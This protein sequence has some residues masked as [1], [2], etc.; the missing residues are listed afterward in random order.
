M[1]GFDHDLFD[2]KKKEVNTLTEKITF[3]QFPLRQEI[4]CALNKKKF[5]NPSPVQ[6]QV[7]NET[8]IMDEDLIVQAKT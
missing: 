2:F 3:K 5:D 6:V 4:L 1:S 7:M 8:N